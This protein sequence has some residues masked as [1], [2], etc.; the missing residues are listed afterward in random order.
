MA[1]VVG[2]KRQNLAADLDASAAVEGDEGVGPFG[3]T[4]ANRGTESLEDTC[5]Q[6]SA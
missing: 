1:G 5:Q 4:H 3:G 6:A 2:V